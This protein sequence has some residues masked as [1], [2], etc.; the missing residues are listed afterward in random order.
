[1]C[2]NGLLAPLPCRRSTQVEE[3]N[4]QWRNEW[5]QTKP[6]SKPMATCACWGHCSV[7]CERRREDKYEGGEK[8]YWAL[9]YMPLVTEERYWALFYMPLV[10]EEHYWALFY[11]PLVTEEHYW[12]LFYMPLAKEERYW[13]LFY[14]PLVTEERYWALF[15]M[16]LYTF[17]HN[18]L[19]VLVQIANKIGL[20]K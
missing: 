3:I 15:Y 8:R 9:F 2:Q 1:M 20:Q 13:A 12:A 18:L 14:M 5:N 19:N 17:I 10:T 7:N 6:M 4:M 11:M 16:P